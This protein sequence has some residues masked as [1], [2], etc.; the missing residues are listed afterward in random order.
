LLTKIEFGKQT[1]GSQDGCSGYFD[2]LDEMEKFV[3]YKINY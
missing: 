2:A 1:I 3:K